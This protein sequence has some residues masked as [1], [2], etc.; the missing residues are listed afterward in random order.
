MSQ[1]YNQAK[2]FIFGY[3]GRENSN[4]RSSVGSNIVIGDF[5]SYFQTL[6]LVNCFVYADLHH[7]TTKA[8]F[9]EWRS[10]ETSR[11]CYSEFSEKTETNQKEW[12]WEMRI[13]RADNEFNNI[14]GLIFFSAKIMK[15]ASPPT[16]FCLDMNWLGKYWNC[17]EGQ[18]RVYHH[19]GPINLIY[20]LREGLAMIAEE[21]LEKCWDRHRSV[22]QKLY[23]GTI[24]G[25]FSS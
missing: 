13:I 7:Y 10:L 5:L 12:W 1:L 3:F 9:S 6:C 22:A 17:F 4:I 25:H 19:T 20:G 8:S 16:S 2:N 24:L 21:G 11:K 14:N 18:G 15:R 23:Q